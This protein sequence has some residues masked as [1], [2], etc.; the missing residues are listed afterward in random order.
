MKKRF[1]YHSMICLLAVSC[2][3]QEIDTQPIPTVP[4]DVFYAC[5]ES[6][7][8]PD[9]KV[10]VNEDIELR[11]D[12]ED[13]LS[14]FDKNTL[15]HP[16]QFSGET[17]DISGYF[18]SV[19]EPDGEGTDLDLVYA[20][21]PYRETTTI[22]DAGVLTLTLPSEQAFKENTFGP[23]VNAMVSA[24]KDNILKF[25]NLCGYLVLKFQ[26]EG[27]SVSSIKL[28]GHDG[29]KL[30]G[31]ATVTPAV[32][33][34]PEIAMASTAGTSIM[35]TFENPVTLG[36]EPTVFWMVV[37]PTHFTQG[38]RLTLTDTDGHVF[39]KDTGSDLS[40]V[41]NGVLRISPITVNMNGNGL[42]ISDVSPSNANLNYMTDVDPDN[43]IITVTMPTVTDFSHMTFDYAFSGESLLADGKDIQSGASI[44]ASKPVTLTVRE[45]TQGINYTLIAQNTGLPVVRITTEGF[46]QQ[47]LEDD[48]E[49]E[50]WRPTD[51]DDPSTGT[52]TIRIEWPDGKKDLEIATQIKGRG[53]ATWTY[54]KRPFALKLSK[55]SAVLGMK[56][57]KRWILLANWKDRTL[58]RNDAA[59]W[60]S[61]QI[62][63]VIQSPSFPYSVH[64]QFVELEFNGVHRGNYYLC[65]QIKI[66]DNRVPIHEFKATDI[67][68]GYLM[69]VDNNYDEQ[70]RFLSGFYGTTNYYGQITTTYGLKY[71]FKEPDENLPD[72]A[73]NYMKGFIQDMEAL[74]KQIRNNTDNYANNSYDSYGY[75]QYLDMD[76]AIWFMFVNELT[77]NGDFFNTDGSVDS[78][79]YGPHSTY[80]YKDRD[81][82][83]ANGTTTVSRL[84]MGPVWDFDYHTFI[85]TLTT[86]SWGHSTSSE[87]RSHKWIG[88]TNKNYYYYYLC[89]DPIFR[90]RMLALWDEYKEIITP[91]AF[92][93][94][95]NDMADHISLSEKFNTRMWGYTNTDQDQG[96]NGDNLKS[97]REAV[98][99]MI[100]AFTEKRAFMDGDLENLNQ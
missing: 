97:F 4:E 60:L 53:N 68:G 72:E 46:T 55:K 94:Y 43:R 37:P 12:A 2:T 98:A 62:S 17:G 87:D 65:E 96:Q 99:L 38:F 77:G 16:Y 75:R 11:W 100:Q 88:A 85:S 9:T 74:I 31:E 8:A 86:T 64:G 84:H 50:T 61:Q 20:V 29:E 59:F 52:A 21:Y 44:D 69:E 40:I 51:P 35:L 33:E 6:Q 54:D 28:E 58:L 89:K 47:T 30:S 18:T 56:K 67:T 22:S 63:D 42:G 39:I 91:E 93:E 27:V 45:G 66:D 32:G 70:Y 92:E 10:Y 90:A 76:S 14:I 25:K 3:V 71:M 19:S 79:W 73:F 48:D 7:S 82:R 5:L 15:N 34:D 13:Q 36:E 1:L 78:K 26:G 80:F 95:V 81:I 83:N 23:G 57:H 49:H 41:R 24:T